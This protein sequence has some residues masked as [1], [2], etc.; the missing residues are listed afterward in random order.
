M[1][2]VPEAVTLSDSEPYKLEGK[3]GIIETI[4]YLSGRFKVNTTLRYCRNIARG[5]VSAVREKRID[6]LVMGWHGGRSKTSHF[7]LGSTIDPIIERAACDVVIMKNCD[8]RPCKKI[9]IPVAGG[10]NSSLA[11]RV[12]DMVA[13]KDVE[14]TVFSVVTRRMNFD[15]SAIISKELDNIKTPT[16]QI[17]HKSVVSENVEEAI[18]K[19]AENYDMMVIGATRSSHIFQASLPESIASKCDKPIIMVS[20]RR[21]KIFGKRR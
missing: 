14:L 9:L 2:P 18:L 10:P 21:R 15:P 1:V 11:L 19:E 13:D 3:E 6:M 4:L 16:E 7:A 17:T 12:A 5:I 8:S 20:A